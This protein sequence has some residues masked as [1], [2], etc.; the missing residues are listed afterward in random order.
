MPPNNPFLRAV[1]SISSLLDRIGFIWLWLIVS[2]FLLLI[3]A[4]INPI[5]LASYIWAAS[6]I[7]MAATIGF[8]VDLTVF[9]GADPRYLEGIEKSMAQT[10][11]VTLLGCAMLAAGLIG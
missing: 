9:R 7:T 5:L 11:R 10:R 3:V 2:L 8:G 6:K 4:L 1:T